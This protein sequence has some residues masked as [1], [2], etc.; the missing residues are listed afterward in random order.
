MHHRPLPAFLAERK[1]FEANNL[2]AYPVQR[3]ER[4]PNAN[5][6]LTGF[7]KSNNMWY[8]IQTNRGATLECISKKEKIVVRHHGEDFGSSWETRQGF[9]FFSRGVTGFNWGFRCYLSWLPEVP[10]HLD[11]QFR[12]MRLHIYYEGTL[13]IGDFLYTRSSALAVGHS[14][15]TLSYSININL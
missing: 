1:L 3:C 14:T 7:C 9:R 2:Q 13:S 6:C 15:I 8:E 10:Y 12:G 5:C 4:S 11:R